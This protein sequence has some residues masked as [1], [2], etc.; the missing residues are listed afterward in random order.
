M[1][2]RSPFL[3]TALTVAAVTAGAAPAMAIKGGTESVQPYSFM[4][5]L[6]RPGDRGVSPKAA[7][8]CGVTLVAP[9]WVVTASHC[10]QNPNDA[11]VGT[12]RGW[13]VRIGSQ[14]LT[15]GGQVIPVDRFYRLSNYRDPGKIYGRDLAVLHL[16]TPAQ[17][18][19]AQLSTQSPAVGTPTRIMGWGMVCDDRN[20][21][22][23]YPDKL[24]E[25]DT[26]TEPTST[27]SPWSDQDLCIGTRNGSISATDMDSGGPALVGNGAGWTL[28]GAVS[29]GSSDAPTDYTNIARFAGWIRGIITGTAVPPEVPVPSLAGR[30]SLGN[31]VGSVVRTAAS[32]PQDPAL[33]LTNGHCIGA[34]RPAPG[35]AIVD[36]PVKLPVEIGDREGYAQTTA[37]AVRLV[38]AT[39]T[40]TDV[41]LFRLDKTYAQ[42]TADGAKT[43]QLSTTPTRAGDRV[44]AITGTYRETCTI[45]AVIPH[46]REQAYLTDNVLRYARSADCNLGPGDSG[47][48]LVAPDGNT[49]VGIH[50]TSQQP[51][52]ENNPCETNQDG[53]VIS[54]PGRSYGQQVDGIP[55]CLAPGSVLDLSR[56]GCTLTRP[57]G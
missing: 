18:H 56:P 43:F 13:R 31:C 51:C 52:I 53:D 27:C 7:H 17:G 35:S 8:A 40:G 39:M 28:I 46:L 57:T 30:V 33:L 34:N 41:A 9:Q 29:G 16:K 10:A 21:P 24:R 6:Q 11:K 45:D 49:V 12:P 5:S 1:R 26:Q 38:Y 42:L 14:S 15:S 25:A 48:P 44:D 37:N 36:Q 55:A 47:S 19:P 20:N 23:C 50:N 3:V 2:I 32:R 4:G 22:D 54:D